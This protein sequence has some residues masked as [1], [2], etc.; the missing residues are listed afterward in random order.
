[1]FD[2]NLLIEKMALDENEN[3][4][5][6]RNNNKRKN[7]EIS[8]EIRRENNKPLRFYRSFEEEEKDIQANY[9]NHI[10]EINYY[11]KLMPVNAIFE[12]KHMTFKLIRYNNI[13][14]NVEVQLLKDGLL[15]NEKI[16]A[17]QVMELCGS[18][19]GHRLFS[20]VYNNYI[21]KQLNFN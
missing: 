14:E 5:N 6:K 18:F 13:T 16:L 15:N 2:E 4:N 17:G 21:I 8:Y 12:Y 9:P 7:S 11:I 20:Y 3:I 10:G 1:M 19:I